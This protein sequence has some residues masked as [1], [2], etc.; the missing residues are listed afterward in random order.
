MGS[1]QVLSKSLV[2]VVALF[3]SAHFSWAIDT[4]IDKTSRQIEQMKRAIKEGET[5]LKQVPIVIEKLESVAAEQD[6]LAEHAKVD[7]LQACK[8][9]MDPKECDDF[10]E[11]IDRKVTDEERSACLGT[12][13][14]PRSCNF[15]C[16]IMTT[17]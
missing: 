10:V 16:N 13:C 1:I 17:M 14:R 5:T 8:R 2:L 11:S 3:I 9:R 4:E 7:F 15:A 6:R 12:I